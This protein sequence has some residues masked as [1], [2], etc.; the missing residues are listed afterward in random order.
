MATSDENAKML[1]Q[2]LD[3]IEVKIDDVRTSI[4]NIEIISGK[5]SVLLDGQ[6]DSLVE[7]MRR[8][9]LLEVKAEA[10][11]KKWAMLQGAWKLVA[12]VAL[13]IEAYH[14]LKGSL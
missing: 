13:L 9:K 10:S 8:T 1:A 6:H 11:D 12:L 5:Q 7:H 14:Y 2:R 4:T 3:K